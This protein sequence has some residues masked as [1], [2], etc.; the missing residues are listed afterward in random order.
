MGNWGGGPEAPTSVPEISG[1][2][3]MASIA[4]RTLVRSSPVIG[5]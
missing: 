5:T 3:A 1:G 2:Q 4:A